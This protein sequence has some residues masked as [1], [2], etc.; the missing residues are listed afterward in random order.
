MTAGRLELYG[1]GSCPHTTELREHLEWRHEDFV[2]YDVES[3]AS[4]FRRLRLLTRGA[5]VVPVLVENG[6]V[7]TIGWQGRS[8]VVAGPPPEQP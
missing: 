1:S 3:D 8:C 7:K 6:M 5:A 4:A 2:E